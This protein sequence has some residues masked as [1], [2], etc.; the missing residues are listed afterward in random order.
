MGVIRLRFVDVQRGRDGRV[1]YHY[2]R[3]NGR[4]WR[5]PGSPGSAE[6]AGAY[7]RL[8]PRPNPAKP[9]P[10]L[11]YPPT[12]IGALIDDYFASPEFRD[13]KPNTQRVYRIVLEPLAKRIGR[14]AVKPHRTAA[15][16]SHA[17]RTIRNTGR[18]QTSP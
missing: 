7:H 9:A 13:T 1:L 14:T 15:R 16:Q 10:Q 3:R 2:F 11:G 5:L 4:R 18:W 8:Q 6:F 17:G 12:S